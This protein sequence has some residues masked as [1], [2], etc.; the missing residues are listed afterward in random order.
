MVRRRGILELLHVGLR[1]LRIP[2][3]RSITC[4]TFAG[5]SGLPVVSPLRKAPFAAF[6]VATVTW[7]VQWL[8]S[9]RSSERYR[10]MSRSRKKAPV[11][12]VVGGGNGKIFRR[13]AN[14]AMRARTRMAI[15][16]GIFDHAPQRLEEVSCIWD[17]K[18]WTRYVT[19]EDSERMHETLKQQMRKK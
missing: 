3:I 16:Q 8:P 6:N 18:D 12:C 14:K 13:C 1:W 4:V 2:T 9:T 5:S 19:S 17:Y 7:I 10:S 11:V 15:S